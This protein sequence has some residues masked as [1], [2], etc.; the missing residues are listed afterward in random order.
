M[1]LTFFNLRTELKKTGPKL[2]SVSD[3]PPPSKVTQEKIRWSKRSWI[4]DGALEGELLF[5][6]G[7]PTP[8]NVPP[9]Q[10]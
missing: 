5:M 2:P 9:L 1:D 10:K 7:Q 4:G 8:P 3:A 6:A